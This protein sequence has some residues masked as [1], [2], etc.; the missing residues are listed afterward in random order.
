MNQ[1][2]KINALIY[3]TM[4]HGGNKCTCVLSEKPSEIINRLRDNGYIVTLDK[5]CSLIITIS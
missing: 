1:L 2:S 3:Y 4:C 5:L